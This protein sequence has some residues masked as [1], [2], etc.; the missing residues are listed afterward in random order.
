M[1]ACFAAVDA[2]DELSTICSAEEAQRGVR[3]KSAK[4]ARQRA[5]GSMMMRERRVRRDRQRRHDCFKMAICHE[6][7]RTRVSAGALRICR[8]LFV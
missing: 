7:A 8:P 6:P 5:A 1:P 2:I 3:R 4:D